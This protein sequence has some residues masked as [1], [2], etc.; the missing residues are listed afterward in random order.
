[1]GPSIKPDGTNRNCRKK[2]NDRR[3]LKAAATK[4]DTTSEEADN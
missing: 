3:D 2:K 4:D 1:M